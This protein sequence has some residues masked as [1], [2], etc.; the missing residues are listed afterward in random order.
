MASAIDNIKNLKWWHFALIFLAILPITAYLLRQN[1][2]RM[3]ELRDVVVAIDQDSGDIAKIEPALTELRNFVLTHMNA[4]LPSPLELQGSFNLSVEQA[5][6]KAEKSGTANGGIYKQAQAE[7]ERVEIPLSVRAQCI[8]NYVTANAK[9]GTDVQELQIPPKEQFVYSFVSP[10]L[11]FDL[12][13]LATIMTFTLFIVACVKFGLEVAVP[14][15]T[16]YVTKQ[17]LE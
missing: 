9:P 11:S 17:P 16:S 13:G 5:R 4:S 7:C 15:L 3:L 14:K 2:L 6:K 12:A 8:Q 10:T 1:N